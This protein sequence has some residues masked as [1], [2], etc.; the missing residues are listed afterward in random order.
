MPRFVFSKEDLLASEQLPAGWY[1]LDVKAISDWTKGS[2]DPTS[3]NVIADFTVAGPIKVG[4]PVRHWFSEKVL[5]TGR[6]MSSKYL[7]CFIPDGKV[8][9]GE[10]Y[11]MRDTVGKKVDGYCV[12]N[13]EMKM[14]SIMEFRRYKAS[15]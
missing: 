14:N 5:G 1:T 7:A 9:I 6:D 13:E 8:T 3:N 4:V 10:G 12:W 2:R 11:E 15:A